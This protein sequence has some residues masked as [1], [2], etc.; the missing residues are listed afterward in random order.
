M[1]VGLTGWPSLEAS[2]EQATCQ[3]EKQ[4][5]LAHAS[6]IECKEKESERDESSTSVGVNENASL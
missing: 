5:T 2:L 1:Y 3:H 6:V 4:L